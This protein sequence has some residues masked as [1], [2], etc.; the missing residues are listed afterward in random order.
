MLCLHFFL[1]QKM[2]IP[3]LKVDTSLKNAFTK[4]YFHINHCFETHPGEWYRHT[5]RRGA[6]QSVANCKICWRLTEAGDLRQMAVKL[7]H[8]WVTCKAVFLTV[9]FLFGLRGQ[10]TCV[11]TVNLRS[12][13]FYLPHLNQSENQYR[14]WPISRIKG[15]INQI[16]SGSTPAQELVTHDLLGAWR[17]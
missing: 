1:K 12:S 16:L 6:E 14:V 13:P 7:F 4:L 2:F 10:N 11:D 9:H 5:E 17:G 8:A 3:I 15:A